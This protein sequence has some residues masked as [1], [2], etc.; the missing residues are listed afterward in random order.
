[1]L[2]TSCSFMS[3]RPADQYYWHKQAMHRVVRGETLY[4]IAFKL[5]MD[6]RYLAQ[7]NNLHWPYTLYVGQVLRLTTAVM[8]PHHYHYKAVRK[9]HYNAPKIIHHGTW[10]WPLT[11]RVVSGFSPA[12]GHKGI[13]ILGK[14]GQSIHAAASGIVAYAGSGLAGYGNLIIIKHNNQYLTAYGNNSINLVK[15]GQ[16]VKANQ[17]IGI[18]GIVD[19]HYWGSHFEVR[20]VGRPINPLMILRA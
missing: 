17:V 19:H 7:I 8:I 3:K 9:Q 10:Y 12:I 15:E 2:L 16:F 5:D 14:K 1:M 18:I 6:Y 20:R 4:A 11:G 13:N